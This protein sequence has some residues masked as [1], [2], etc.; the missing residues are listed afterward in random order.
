MN[1]E[2]NDGF[3]LV[4]AKSGGRPKNIFLEKRRGVVEFL[5]ENLNDIDFISIN[6]IN[7]DKNKLV[8]DNLLLCRYLKLKKIYEI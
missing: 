7:I 4:Y 2:V 5:L 8:N 6:D 3:N 1:I